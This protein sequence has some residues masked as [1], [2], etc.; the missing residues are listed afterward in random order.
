MPES[1]LSFQV[2]PDEYQQVIQ[3]AQDQ[4]QITITPLQELVG[5]WSGA[6]I[7]LV[8]VT[9]L[10]S[11]TV[12]HLILKLDRIRPM[13]KSDEITRHRLA[14]E[15]SPPAFARQ[16]IPDLVYERVE[17]D[18]ILAIFYAIAGQSLHKFRTLSRHRRQ[19]QLET[20]FS[21]TNRYLLDEWNAGMSIE[22][23]D[24]PQLLLKRWLGFR[25]D[26][27]QKI[28]SFLRQ[29]CQIRP[30]VPGFIIQGI[31][32]PNPLYY[33]REPEPWGVVR[34][35]DAIVGLQHSDLNTNNILAKYSPQGDTLEGYYLIDFALFKENMPLL[36]DQR[37]LEMSF[38]AHIISGGSISSVIDLITRLGE[39]EVLDAQ[40][41]PI[42][43]SGVN[44]AI[45]AGRTAFEDWVQQHHPSLHDDLWGQYWLAGAAAGLSYCHKAGQP[46]EIRLAGLIFA[47]TNLKQYCN[48]FGLNMPVGASQL[49]VEEQLGSK[50]GTG[51]I[52]A[53]PAGSA[54]H[55]LPA[56]TT[57][58]IG[59]KTQLTEVTDLLRQSQA[60][61]ITLTGPGGTGKT[62]LGLEA[63][64]SMLDQ[65]PHGI[66]FIDLAPIQD[67]ALLASTIAH[68]LG[69]REGGGLPPLEKL[70][71][72]FSEKQML[73]LFDN[74]EH[75]TAAA[76]DVAELLAAA[77]G[78]K[79]LVTSRIALQLRGE[80]E[81]PVS[82]LETPPETVQSLSEALDYEAVALFKQQ[83]WAV[84]PHF[85]ITEENKQAVIEICR[86]LDGLPL[87][88]EIAAARI[89]MLPPKALLKRLNQSLHLLVSG[90]VDLPNR[91]Q[92]LRQTIDWSYEL[93]KPAE[94]TLFTRLGIFAGGFN[95]EAAEEVCNPTGE[96]DVF[97]GVET[98]LNNSLLRQV[99]SVSDEPRFD[100]LQTI[101]DY[102]LE[103]A[104]E[105]GLLD[106]MHW[107]HCAYYA[108]L[109]E[110]GTSAG[111]F[112][113]YSVFWLHR[114]NEE[115]DNFRVALSWA[116]QQEEGIAPGISMM[117]PLTWFWYRYG[118][119]KE[120]SEWTERALS[121]TSSLGDT[122]ARA[123]ALA[124]RGFLA[125]W[126]G[127]L[128][129]AVERTWESMEMC[130]KLGFDMGLSMAKLSY[131]VTLINQGRDK[132]A[133][134]HL[135]DAV[136]LYDQ[137]N[138]PWMKGTAL[139]HLANVSLGL[140]DPDQAVQWLDMAMPF[141]EQSGDIWNMAFALNN[142]GEVARV[143]GD[144]EKAEKYYRRTEELY[145]QADAV[146]DQARLV[147]TF[148][149]IAQHKGDYENAQA[150]FLESLSD[151]RKL[152]NHRGIAECLAGL[153]GLAA[154][155]GQH[156]WAAPLLSAAESQLKA[157]G[158][159]W[160]PAD[161][162]EIERAQ[163]RMKSALGDEF[164][165]LWAQGQAMN[166]TEAIAYASTLE[167]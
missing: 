68:T 71:S 86:R 114:F 149:Y 6:Y 153:A 134:P 75:L 100:M 9:S 59:R 158:G 82:P 54:P 101:R 107:A 105:S 24:H 96:I 11:G 29:E 154:E 98:L 123:L 27:G 110:G 93:L 72:Y 31:V 55:N 62:R 79:A 78:I 109:A 43:M 151:F 126:S 136:E 120:G 57:N 2:L 164:E 32:T 140:G 61:L 50:I 40:R 167:E 122:P 143:L 90:A 163:E 19:S 66:Y 130:Q 88:I 94:Q 155:Q 30:D 121:A 3:L 76:P 131:G 116:M 106:E 35:G 70:K 69:L 16:H 147:H 137:Q 14:Q 39:Q 58:F 15:K 10:D 18:N 132:E 4:H 81:Y 53:P 47:A 7:Y 8:S 95:L 146:G 37:Y 115:H 92:T 26:P 111:I 38:L 22:Q 166:V 144:Y 102:A 129:V 44:A 73:L 74:F 49:Y 5:G 157:F 56:P 112:G 67:P 1:G 64:R 150:L 135:V 33:A 160:W 165:A 148:G 80:H 48:L 162:V 51:E 133:Y 65:F 156:E 117:T 108:Q 34:P 42:E 119:L 104:T 152:G 23:V 142:Y 85:E 138:Q 21:T 91:Q 52:P 45:H 159:A 17:K 89:K 118:H 127:D 125:L 128:P 83:A 60:R 161:R 36:Y 141:M 113:S 25:L 87:A 46:T 63:S 20:L 12:E 103:K 97:S 28:E 124:G 99:K 145:E 84:Q 77:P 13:A 139:V 41:T